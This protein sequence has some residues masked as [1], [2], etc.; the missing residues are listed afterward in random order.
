M[1]AAEVNEDIAAPGDRAVGVEDVSALRTF[2]TGRVPFGCAGGAPV[3]GVVGVPFGHSN[4]V[5]LEVGRL[6]G[7][8]VGVLRD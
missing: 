1:L 2:V 8:R 5:R 4:H 7:E 6:G 3:G